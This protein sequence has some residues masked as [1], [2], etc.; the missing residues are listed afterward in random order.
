MYKKIVIKGELATLNQY[1][2]AMNIS[3]YMGNKVKQ[4]D[5]DACHWQI[6]RHKPPKPYAGRYKVHFHWVTKD[7]YTDADNVAY[8]KKAVLDSFVKCG[9][10]KDDSRKYINGFI[11]TFDVDPRN[12]RIEIQILD[13]E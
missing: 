12:P 13:Y 8:A 10:L 2:A 3:L 7:E 6:K 1:I 9:I 4:D 11:D 5:T